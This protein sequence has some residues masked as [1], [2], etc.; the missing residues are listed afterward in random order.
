M[1]YLHAPQCLLLPARRPFGKG[2]IQID[3]QMAGPFCCE[4]DPIALADHSQVRPL[5]GD[6]PKSGCKRDCRTLNWGR[7][8]SGCIIVSKFTQYYA[9][10][11]LVMQPPVRASGSCE[12][13]SVS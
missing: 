1:W 4:V 3:H 8:N 13:I 7:W 6:M 5:A 10:V 11:A 2:E 12:V 9:F